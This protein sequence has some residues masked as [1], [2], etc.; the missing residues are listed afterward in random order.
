MAHS[1]AQGHPQMQGVI[2]RSDRLRHGGPQRL[3]DRLG[4]RIVVH[5]QGHRKF[6]TAHAGKQT[7]LAHGG[8][9]PPGHFDQ[10][11]IA[12]RETEVL[13]DDPHAVHGQ[14]PH[15]NRSA[16]GRVL[17]AVQ[18]GVHL[19]QEHRP[20]GQAR[21][22]VIEIGGMTGLLATSRL[23][24]GRSQQAHVCHRLAGGP[25]DDIQQQCLLGTIGVLENHQLG[26][27][28]GA[29]IDALRDL[30]QGAPQA[31]QCRHRLPFD[32]AG[33]VPAQQAARTG[34]RRANHAV[35]VHH[36]HALLGVL[37]QGFRRHCGVQCQHAVSP[38]QHAH[39]QDHDRRHDRAHRHHGDV[40]QEQIR[41]A[42]VDG[43]EA[44][45]DKWRNHPV[46]SVAFSGAR[47][48]ATPQGEQVPP[49]DPRAGPNGQ[50]IHRTQRAV[51]GLE[52]PGCR[53]HAIDQPGGEDD[54][55]AGQQGTEL[56]GP[57]PAPAHQAAPDHDVG[58][59]QRRGH[60]DRFNDEPH[61]GQ[62]RRRQW[63][64]SRQ[65]QRAR[66]VPQRDQAG[67]VVQCLDGPQVA[68]DEVKHKHH[69]H[70]QDGR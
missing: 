44:H 10:D 55:Q 49:T 29:V 20:P 45:G 65:L 35:L 59:F 57:Q 5:P 14:H 1:Q 36:Q 7:L 6:V 42:D 22:A 48:A 16:L 24:H 61:I 34:I 69:R 39:T 51:A 46:Q 47:Q 64:D 9:Q 43:H 50:E 15:G 13:V 68:F 62:E 8:L 4:G 33:L 54:E 2:P 67:E 23:C 11:A 40:Q 38:G 70:A 66:G 60:G 32:V 31:Q 58:E 28:V 63:L 12:H 26:R 21:E 41:R 27:P 18:S 3:A 56:R 52:T 53:L 19:A 17:A 30:V 37:H 25:A